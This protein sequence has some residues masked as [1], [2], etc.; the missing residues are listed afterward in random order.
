MNRMKICPALKRALCFFI[1][2]FSLIITIRTA[3]MVSTTL[4]D[5]DTASEM[6]LGEKLARE[7]GIMST[8]WL[9]STEL[10]VVDSQ[11]IYSL[12]F[13]MTS[14]WSLV[15]FWGSVLMD[16]MM[17]GAFG[18]LARQARIPFNRFCIAGAVMMLPFS[19]PY[20]RIVLYH[21]YYSFHIS[22]SFLIVGLY[23]GAVRRLKN[24]KRIPFWA[25][26]AGLGLTALAACLTGVRDLMISI[27]PLLAS[28]AICAM[29]S[30]KTDGTGSRL[31]PELPGLLI[32][33]VPLVFGAVGYLINL[34]V[35]ANQYTYKDFSN[36]TI[37][38]GAFAELYKVIYNTFVDL[39]FQDFQPLFSMEGLLGIGGVTAWILSIFLAVH[40]IRHTEEP[41]ARFL[42]VFWL[43]VQLVMTCV[44]IFISSEELLYL[45]YLLPII[46][47]ILP[48]LASADV[49]KQFGVPSQ[50]E[51]SDNNKLKS[52]HSGL[53]TA[54]DAAVSVHGVLSILA[55][56]LLA[57]SG[58]Y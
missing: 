17:L 51:Q 42:Q 52:K 37:A 18:L 14:D 3:W 19:I 7:G 26:C 36:Q 45:L 5:S 23:L 24:W 31:K 28:A 29:M 53:L 2:L 9:Y 48:A 46:I 20:G 43:M 34:N 32:A 30:E 8:S 40:T 41:A 57:A 38:M 21:N 4:I 55:C 58:L 44:F 54:G 47:W 33:L 25:M 12:L 13:R 50:E 10:Q 49:R 22:L 27:V 15:R 11:I 1:L 39:G 35:L 56:L 6:I 16:L